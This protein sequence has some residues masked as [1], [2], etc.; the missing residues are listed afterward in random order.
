MTR[1][2]AIKILRTIVMIGVYG[3]L[4]MPLVFVPKVIFPFVFSKLIYLQILIGLTFPAYLVL[5]WIEPK[6]RPKWIPLTAAITAYFAALGLSV[7][8]A[9]DVSRAWWGNQERMNGLFTLLHFFAW[10]LMASSLLKTWEQWK[11]FLIYEVCLS[12][13]MA[14][15][16]ILQKPF[17]KLLMFP[18]GDRVGGLLDNPI[19]MAAYQIFNLFFIALLWLKGVSKS[20]K[21]W[22]VGF[23]ILD[24]VAFLLAQSRG[25]LVGLGAGIVVF[26]IVYALFTKNKKAK[27]TILGSTLALFLC[28]GV[29][30]ALRNTNF[31]MHTPLE[32]LTNFQTTVDTRFIAWKIAWEGFLERPLTGWGLDDFHILFNLKYNPSSLQFGYYETWFDRSHNTVMD[33]LS[34]TGIFGALTFFGLYVA[35]F[36]STVKAF[37][38][39]WIDLPTMSIFFALPV[40]YFVQNLFVFDQPAGFT[41]SFLMFALIAAATS[42]EFTGA[43]DPEQ[44]VETKSKDAPVRSMPWIAFGVLQVLALLIVWRFSWLPAK[45]SVISID[46]NNYFSAGMLNEAFALA[47]QAAAIPTPYLDEQTFLQSR[48]LMALVDNGTAQ[49]FPDWKAWHDLIVDLNTRYL[50][51]H[52]NNTN[53]LFIYARFLDDFSSIIPQDA[54]LAEQEYLAA[55]KTSPERQQLYYSFARF[56]IVHGQKDKGYQLYKQAEDFDPTIGESHWYV[57]LTLVYDQN[58]FDEGSKELIAAMNAPTPYSLKDVREATAVADAYVQEKDAA[59]LKSLITNILPGLPNGTAPTFLQI[60]QDAELLGLIPERNYI[61][62][63]LSQDPTIAARLQPLINGSAT[64]I[65]R[66]LE[67]TQNLASST[68]PAVQATTTAQAATSSAA[69]S[70]TG[71]GP[72]LKK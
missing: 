24:I 25:A 64:S 4:L 11:R 48:N 69:S 29:L 13:F 56:Y 2:Q 35:L 66:S 17:P 49:K 34:M 6:Y 31:V 59:G 32:R 5:A 23:A 20:T 12:A 47:K 33:A 28:Y 53:P 8:F 51:E 61:L 1:P 52:P 22:L 26:A 71:S 40:A 68:P 50:A 63:A 18:A 37:R 44:V 45:A 9:V 62:G 21:V 16:A 30:F 57:G 65:D 72:R 58:K 10:Y 27:I 36:Y 15:V 14:T 43:K 54:A 70:D 46:S 39:K 41:M 7:V 60:A 3:G 19:Y 38:K 67:M 55:V 42:A